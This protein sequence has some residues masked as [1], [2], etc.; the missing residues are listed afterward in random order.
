MTKYRTIPEQASVFVNIRKFLTYILAHN[1]PQL[2]PNLASRYCKSLPLT[3]IQILSI[4]G[5][6]SLTALGLA[7]CEDRL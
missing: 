4:M 2:I 5:T 3:R 7:P 1:V 6:D